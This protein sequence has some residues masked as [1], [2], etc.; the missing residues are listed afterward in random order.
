VNARGRSLDLR[1]I[2]VGGSRAHGGQPMPIR[3]VP[4]S[5]LHLV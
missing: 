3:P 2:V 1:Q 5:T 4:V